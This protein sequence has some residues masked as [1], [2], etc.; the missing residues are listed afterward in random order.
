MGSMKYLWVSLGSSN[1]MR[2]AMFHEFGSFWTSYCTD[3]RDLSHGNHNYIYHTILTLW[4]VDVLAYTA[5]SDF[6]QY[7]A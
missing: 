4:S 5:R 1:K 2:I 7:P 3:P 6:L